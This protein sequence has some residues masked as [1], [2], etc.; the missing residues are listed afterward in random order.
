MGTGS[1]REKNLST[2]RMGVAMSRKLKQPIIHI[3]N[4]NELCCTRAI[5]TLKARA[6]LEIVM[7]PKGK[8]KERKGKWVI[9]VPKGRK[10]RESRE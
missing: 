3:L 7:V 9:M 5:V 2:G 8:G 4:N 1:G 10:G 6:E